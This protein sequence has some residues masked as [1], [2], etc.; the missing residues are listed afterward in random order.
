MM[1]FEKVTVDRFWME[2]VMEDLQDLEQDLRSH[3]TGMFSELFALRK[4]VMFV[5]LLQIAQFALVLT[6]ICLDA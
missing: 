2:E 4:M 6:L 3:D 1:D 5:T